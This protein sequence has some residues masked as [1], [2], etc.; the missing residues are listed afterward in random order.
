M[1]ILLIGSGGREHALAWKMARSPRV[2][3]VFVAPGNGGTAN[4]KHEGIE[5]LPISDLQELADFAKRE[6]I[7]L[8]VVGPEAPLAAGIV[9]VFRNQ[10]LRIF[11]PTQLAAQLESSKD[12]S[13]AFMKRYGI[14]TADYRTFSNASEAHNYIDQKGAPIVIKADGLA[15]G[16]GVVVAMSLPEA[17]MAV[18]MMLSDNKLGNAGA[19]VV[20]EEF[21]IGEEASFIV[22]VDGKN[23]VPLATSQDH[24]RLHDG[25][26]G[27]NTGGMGAYSPAPVVT[28]EIHARAMREVIMPTV[29]GMKA[30]G[31]PYTGF[32]YAGLMISPDGRIKTLEFNCRMGD[33]ETQPIMA[34]LESDLVNAL[35]KA[36]DGKLD[37]VELKWDRRIALGVVLAA[38]QYP[39]TPR[40]GDRISGIPAPTN[41]QIVFHAGTKLHDGNLL[42]SGGRVLCVVG[43]A[44]TVK[45]AQQ[46]AYSAVEQIHFDGMQYRK[47]IGFRA[48]K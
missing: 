28:P 33:P 32:L 31:I 9:D 44:D 6:Q 34:R 20:I 17:H 23:V 10:G 46:K 13:K 14:P 7:A 24:K 47:D 40:S 18:D 29:L 38:H 11:G 22:L 26:Q 2:Q 21:L 5:N 48:I 8:T 43:L 15:A 42:T 39:D 4:Q 37:E 36:I 25:D 12:F 3:K 19:R 1:K 27:P 41:D 16:K 35:D 45:A 30:D